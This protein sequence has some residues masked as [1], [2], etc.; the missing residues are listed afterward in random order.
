MALLEDLSGG[1]GPAEE[2][3]NVPLCATVSRKLQRL[4][5]WSDDYVSQL[6]TLF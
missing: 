6:K 5:Q 1:K 4:S 3:G 2:R